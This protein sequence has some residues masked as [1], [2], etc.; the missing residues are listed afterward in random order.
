MRILP[1][2]SLATLSACAL[3]AHAFE[4]PR[5]TFKGI[6]VRSATLSELRADVL[7][8]I[9][10]PNSIE[11]AVARG[12]LSLSIEGRRLATLQPTGGLR[13]APRATTQLRIPARI[14]YLD[15]ISTASTFH[16]QRSVKFRV[17]GSVGID[18]PIGVLD[19]PIAEEGELP[20]PA[21]P[22]V[23][24][25]SAQLEDVG[26]S[27][28]TLRVTLGVRNPNPV[29]LWLDAVHGRVLLS[30]AEVA[31]VSTADLG[32]VAPGA[33]KQLAVPF[34]LSLGSAPALLGAIAQGDARVRFEGTLQSG[35]TEVPLDLETVLKRH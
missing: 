9:E 32:E 8:D 1:A 31:T 6:E 33:T 15:A 16:H 11:L 35:D 18:T 27:G 12:E 25:E 10:N 28:G 3:L 5:L 30:G 24:V 14:Q 2:T 7:I 13:A 23:S 17:E 20:L 4:K 19:F 26:L 21:L 34:H 22:D 29:P